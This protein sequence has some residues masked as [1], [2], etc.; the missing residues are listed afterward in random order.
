MTTVTVIK[1]GN[2]LA[3]RVPKAYA[4]RNKLRVGAKVVL[5]DTQ[6][7]GGTLADLQKAIEKL[8]GQGGISAWNTVK[9]PVA[10]QR[11][12]RASWTR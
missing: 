9:D 5:P 2:S 6:K 4:E 8:H 1:S 3:L 11:N 10:W 7:V 12:E